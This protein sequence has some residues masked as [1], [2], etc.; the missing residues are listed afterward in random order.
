MERRRG[1]LAEKEGGRKVDWRKFDRR[2]EG[3]EEVRG[4]PDDV[5]WSAVQRA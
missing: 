1:F 3:R 5:D 4:L 2:E